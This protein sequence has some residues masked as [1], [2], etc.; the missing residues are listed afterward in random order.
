[1]RL[2][3]VWITWGSEFAGIVMPANISLRDRRIGY[4]I[5]SPV[6]DDEFD[7]PLALVLWMGRQ[8]A[9]AGPADEMR[10]LYW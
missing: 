7:V 5:L 3:T 8:P 1:M 2:G 6:E 9:T 4:T 10:R